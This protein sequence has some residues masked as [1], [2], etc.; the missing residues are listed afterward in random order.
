LLGVVVEVFAEAQYRG[1]LVHL[2]GKN[3]G[4]Q[5]AARKVERNWSENSRTAE[6]QNSKIQATKEG[7]H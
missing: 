3:V 6:Q 5:Q 2:Q 4:K 1:G 7:H